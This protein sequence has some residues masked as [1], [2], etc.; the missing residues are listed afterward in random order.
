MQQ[1]SSN[2]LISLVK[3][4][5]LSLIPYSGSLNGPVQYL[6]HEEFRQKFNCIYGEGLY[7]SP[8]QLKK[9]KENMFNKEDDRL[10]STLTGL[11][12]LLSTTDIEKGVLQ[13]MNCPLDGLV[14]R[15][16][17]NQIGCGVFTTNPIERGTVV[18]LYSSE[19]IENTDETITRFSSGGTYTEREKIDV[20]SFCYTE[21]FEVSARDIGGIARFINHMPMHSNR[22]LELQVKKRLLD[23]DYIKDILSY[24][25]Q[26]EAHN[27]PQ[28]Y[29]HVPNELITILQQHYLFLC[30]GQCDA[31]T[32]WNDGLSTLAEFIIKHYRKIHFSDQPDSELDNLVFTNNHELY[33]VCTA[34]LVKTTYICP[35]GHGLWVLVANSNIPAG[36]QLGY[37]YGLSFFNACGIRPK[38]FTNNGREM[39]MP[40]ASYHLIGR[41]NISFF[42]YIT[43]NNQP[44]QQFI[45][46]SM[47]SLETQILPKYEVELNTPSQS[48]KSSIMSTYAI[49]DILCANDILLSTY[50]G[51][52][53]YVIGSVAIIREHFPGIDVQAYYANPVEL[54]RRSFHGLDINDINLYKINI[55]CRSENDRSFYT[56]FNFFKAKPHCNAKMHLQAKIHQIVLTSVNDPEIISG[57]EVVPVL[58]E[59]SNLLL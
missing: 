29:I 3:A 41:A 50:Y 47:E 23:L 22:A 55:V 26:G 13:R 11:I 34:N 12:S 19:L 49:R 33:E 35:N 21:I 17:N 18:A 24:I 8:S 43:Y 6:T 38:Y 25:R 56:M 4:A 16:I 44:M 51:K 42:N 53:T 46:C 32:Y 1:S 2:K 9:Y 14:I 37:S 31:K 10:I 30:S 39:L 54:E 58:A 27:N 20:Y 15:K 59:L 45:Q 5:E 57:K 28:V 48:V 7:I 36:A 40:L 52:L